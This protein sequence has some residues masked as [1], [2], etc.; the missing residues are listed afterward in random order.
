MAPAPRAF[1]GVKARNHRKREGC[2]HVLATARPCQQWK[3]IRGRFCFSG[4]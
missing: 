1:G 3:Q 4:Y 2:R